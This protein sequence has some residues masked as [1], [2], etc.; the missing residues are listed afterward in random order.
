[1]S[2]ILRGETVAFYLLVAGLFLKGAQGKLLSRFP[3]FYTYLAYMA[4]TGVV[5]LSLYRWKPDVY[6]QAV[7]AR[8]LT[9]LVAEFVVLL[10]ISDHLFG[11][12]PAVRRL[13]RF[14]AAVICGAFLFAYVLPA[15][16]EAHSSWELTLEL[17]KRASLTKAALIVVLLA[18]SR[19]YRLPMEREVAGLML[20]FTA[21]LAVNVVNFTLDER[22]GAVY[23]QT[24][25]VVGP[26]SYT[27]GM[28]IWTIALWHPKPALATQPASAVRRP[29]VSLDLR[30]EKLNTTLTRLLRR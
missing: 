19:I 8:L 14:L 27:L 9:G 5:T 16:S 29:A 23:F 15:L 4:A 1:M 17:F 26:L 25:G 24:F 21:F 13:G 28:L 6:A 11:R 3:F 10:E 7:W 12:F 30:L 2:A 20:G 18:A 22:Y